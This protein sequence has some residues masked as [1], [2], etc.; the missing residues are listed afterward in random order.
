[1]GE[2]GQMGGLT[3]AEHLLYTGTVLNTLH[4]LVV[5]T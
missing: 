3:F 1:M 5:F 4:A 2:G